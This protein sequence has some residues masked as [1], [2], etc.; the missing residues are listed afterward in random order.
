MEI[1]E[2]VKARDPEQ[3]EFH[4]A[5]E[6]VVE[7]IKPVLDQHP[8][9]RQAKILEREV[10]L[11]AAR[12]RDYHLNDD[13]VREVLAGYAK[14]RRQSIESYAQGGR[15]ELADQEI[16]GLPSL[17]E[18]GAGVYRDKDPA[19]L[20]FAQKPLQIEKE[21][22]RFVLSLHLPFVEKDDLEVF[23]KGEEL[24][25]RVGPLKRNILLPRVLINHSVRGA[26]FVEERLR[27]TFQSDR[28]E[29]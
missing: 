14:Q 13:E 22:G 9:Y 1:M 11:R 21:D 6:E 17:R 18:L 16:F 23:Q 8:E 28:K 12:G 19:S 25:I 4:Q 24:S 5:V 10:D 20:F 27:I 29:A 3:R 7:S 15:A 2:L 26:K